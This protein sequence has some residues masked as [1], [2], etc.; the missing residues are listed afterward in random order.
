MRDDYGMCRREV[1]SVRKALKECLGQEVQAF[2]VGMIE[3]WGIECCWNRSGMT[4]NVS[5]VNIRI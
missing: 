3:Y 1:V 2:N 4:V 5:E